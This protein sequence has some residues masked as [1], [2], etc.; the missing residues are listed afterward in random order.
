MDTLYRT[1]E[2]LGL[3]PNLGIR[4][5]G[6]RLARKPKHVPVEWYNADKDAEN[7]RGEI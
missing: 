3:C 7:R 1:R 5:S 6:P 4:V 2:N